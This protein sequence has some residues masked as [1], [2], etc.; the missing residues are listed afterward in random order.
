MRL[1]IDVGGTNTDAVLIC[2]KKVLASTKQPTSEDIAGGII[3][4]IQ[5][6]ATDAGIAY[7]EIRAVMIGTTQFTNA[8]VERKRLDRVAAIRLCLPASQSLPPF[9]DWPSDLLEAID[10]RYYLSAGGYEYNGEQISPLDIG[11]LENIASDLKKRDIHS[12]AIS[13]VFAPVQS[14]MEERAAEILKHF[15]PNLAITLS[16]DIGR[17][18]LL[19]RENAAIMNASL[20][21]HAKKVVASFKK[22]LFALGISAPF[23]LTQNDGTLMQAEQV[24][25]FPILTFSS[26]PTNS[27]RGAAWLS[28]INSGLVVD[29]GGTTSDIG[30]LLNGYPRESSVSV[31]IGGVRTNF[32]MP[33]VLALGVGGGS[34]VA[35]LGQVGPKS[36]GHELLSTA[37]VFGGE[38]LTASDVAVASGRASFGDKERLSDICPTLIERALVSIQEQLEEGVDRMKTQAG[39]L[40]VILVGGGSI[41]LGEV[42]EGASEIVRP[43]HFA[44]ANAV[45]AAIAQVGGEV[46]KVYGYASTPR[47]E[48]IADAKA[49]AISSAFE[50]GASEDSIAIIDIEEVPLAYLPNGAVRVRV[51]AVGDLADQAVREGQNENS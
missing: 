41:L 1:G 12:V 3:A 2:D 14:E 26:G 47:E 49:K 42:L 50:A 8:F 17:I 13:S 32:R 38:R 23:Y 15:N 34:L 19:E 40:P 51:K 5:Q 4:A 9:A 44:V 30:A 24:A 43:P 33:D 27:M 21:S 22:A 20:A 45:G 16:K 28:G 36:V 39:E 11:D 6:V 35:K 37:K 18:G 25:Q 29:I 46:D 31:D 10:A 48:A 7:S